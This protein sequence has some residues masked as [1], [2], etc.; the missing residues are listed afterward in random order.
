[1]GDITDMI[2]D[3]T[4]DEEGVYIGDTNMN[5]VESAL[6]TIKDAMIEDGPGEPGSLA[7]AWHCNIAM[8]CY[9]AMGDEAVAHLD[10]DEAHRI[11]NDAASRFMKRLFD[12]ETKQ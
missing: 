9:D 12:I 1:M 6:K 8:A 10:H 7:H 11:A 4:L 5:D 3:G 2:L